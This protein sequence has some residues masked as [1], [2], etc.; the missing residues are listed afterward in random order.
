MADRREPDGL[1]PDKPATGG[2]TPGAPARAGSLMINSPLRWAVLVLF[3]LGGV[4]ILSKGFDSTSSAASTGGG[5]TSG[6]TTPP[7]TPSHSPSGHPSH[8][9][10]APS[11]VGITVA[12]YNSTDTPGLA[13]DQRQQLDVAGW[14]VISIGNVH[15]PYPTTTI[16]YLPEAKVQAEYMKSQSYPK[17]ALAQAPPAFRSAKISVVLGSDFTATP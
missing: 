2:S 1:E 3:I 5:G 7:S 17:A 13:S 6:H 12:I 10:S 4:L 14:D 11:L 16:Y 15:T 9:P 8:S